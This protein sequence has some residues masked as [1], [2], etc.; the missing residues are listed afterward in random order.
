MSDPSSAADRT[1]VAVRAR[2]V[3]DCRGLPTVQ[4][5]VVLD[6]GVTG[7][8]DVPSGRSTGSYEACELRD[9]GSRFGGLKALRLLA[10]ITLPPGSGHGPMLNTP[11]G[12]AFFP[13]SG[14][15]KSLAQFPA[16]VFGVNSCGVSRTVF[17]VLTWIL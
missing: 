12:S 17:F 15:R 13:G 10:K 8:A 3:L 14:V 7:T 5:D 9:G 11:N 16:P 2:E 4:V 1:V 6:G